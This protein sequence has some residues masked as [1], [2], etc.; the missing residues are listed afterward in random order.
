MTPI[1]DALFLGYVVALA[2]LLAGIALRF[3]AGRDR[4]LAVGTLAFWLAFV[5]TL[6]ALGIT[7]DPTLRPP[8]LL[9]VAGPTVLGILLLALSPA[10]GRLAQSV[11]VPVLLGL[12]TFRVGVEGT[13]HLFVQAGLA[14]HLLT[15][16]GGNVEVLVGLTAPVAA[17]IAPRG[18]ASRRLAL[19]WTLL[20]VLSLLNVVARAVLTTPGPLHLLNA[21]V[22][23]VAM[24]LFPYAFIPGFMVP[25]A[26]LL[27]GLALRALVARPG[28]LPSSRIP[29]AP[30]R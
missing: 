15:L 11:P 19:A 21:E 12:Q 6:G 29:A 18:E 14:P 27:H 5:G 16:E 1:R 30:A 25:L 7:L 24:G 20:G 13:I 3:L 8:G 23:T 26:L 10:G 28:P 2:A 22:P 4:I 9:L 17:W